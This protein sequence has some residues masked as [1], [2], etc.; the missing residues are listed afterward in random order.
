MGMFDFIYFI[1]YIL[2]QACLVLLGVSMYENMLESCLYDAC[3]VKD[4]KGAMICKAAENLVKEC[5]ENYDTEFIDW[6]TDEMCSKY[7]RDFK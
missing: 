7:V 6:R 3:K 4:D 5:S 2:F 1:L